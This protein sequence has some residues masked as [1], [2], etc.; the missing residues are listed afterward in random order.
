MSREIR[1]NHVGMMVPDMD[2]AIAWYANMFASTVIDRWSNPDAGIEW[3][4]L[5]LGDLLLEMVRMADLQPQG[6]RTY[7]LHHFA[8]TVADCDAFVAELAAKG[9][10]ISR[11]PSDF[12]RHAIRWAFVRD[13]L[14]NVIEIISPISSASAH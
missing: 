5:A 13:H 10:E 7:A 6:A 9:A 3:A 8:L 14:G 1:F 4:H 11:A 12:E 2:A